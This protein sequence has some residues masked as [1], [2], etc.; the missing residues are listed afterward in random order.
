MLYFTHIYFLIHAA[1]YD[2]SWL[3]DLPWFFRSNICYKY[4]C[5]QT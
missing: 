1:A 2:V 4:I 3:I 5:V